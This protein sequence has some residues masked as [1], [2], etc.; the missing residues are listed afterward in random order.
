MDHMTP[1]VNKVNES[2]DI[3]HRISQEKTTGGS[4]GAAAVAG[5]GDL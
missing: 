4:V 5:S 3:S 1:H 2:Y